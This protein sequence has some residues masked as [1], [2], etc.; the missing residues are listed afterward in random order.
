[1]TENREPRDVEARLRASLHAYAEAVDDEPVRRPS[2]GTTPGGR[3]RASVA[4][5]WRVPSLV[6]AAV[7]AV[8]GGAWLVVDGPPPS[9][10]TAAAVSPTAEGG[11]EA[12]AAQPPEEG[13]PA[14][15]RPSDAAA[16]AV[17]P[18]GRLV[19]LP[20]AEVGVAYPFDL[21]TRC[22]V[23]GAD[24]AGVWFEADPALI[25]E[26]GPP[27]GWDDPYSRGTLTLEA[28]DQAVFRDDAGHELVLRAAAESERP[29]PCD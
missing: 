14:D 8:A 15:A 28:P 10:P 1:M 27:S 19:V 4:P 3:D 5:R 6:A 16:A 13:E 29:P 11:P 24:V 12:A 20:P 17:G 7:V 2:A 22:G 26:F 9:S 21:Y 23:V 18:A 25:E